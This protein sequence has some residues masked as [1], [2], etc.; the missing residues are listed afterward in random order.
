VRDAH[1]VTGTVCGGEAVTDPQPSPY[2]TVDFLTDTSTVG[3]PY[4]YYRY[5]RDE[6]GPAWI[7]PIWNV[8]MVT[9]HAEAMAVYRD[10]ENFSSCN[11]PSG[12]W[13]GLPERPESDDASDLIEQYRSQM[14]LY[15]YMVTWDP[16][17]HAAYRS[18]LMGLF[19][20][21]RLAENE[22]FMWRLADE[23]LERFLERGA[24]DFVREFAEPFTF[25]V[26]A[27]LLG[28]PDDDLGRFRDWFR[29]Q[30]STGD[31]DEEVI[32]QR[33]AEVEDPNILGF[34]ESTFTEYI[35]DRRRHPRDDILTHLAQVTFPDGSVPELSVLANEAAFLFAAGQETTARTLSFA[36][37]YLAARPE[38]QQALRADRGLIPVFVE[39]I[40]RLESPIKVH[41]R[42]ARRTVTLGGVTI[43][44]GTTVMLMIGAINRDPDRFADPD[45]LRLDRPN[46]F[47]HI[48]FAKGA[49]SC[50]G[51]QL[52]RTEARVSLH[53]LLDRVED[54][55]ISETHHG[56]PGARQYVYD[57]TFLFRGLT[58]LHVEF[59]AR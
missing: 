16:P 18:L 3:D 12:P 58:A 40:L 38:L 45:E 24:C 41:F 31:L 7:D 52:A 1:R 27:N 28:V 32:L 36:A 5:L 21:T 47:E 43:P 13:P 25:L 57:P 11:A 46:L 19:T 30:K 56:P 17:Q 44:A 9:G 35:A 54:I 34:F 20:P 53:R 14:A 10:D 42:M 4:R 6:H 29:S 26:V 51:Q 33:L 8:A 15:G 50:L 23:E 39:E 49:H 48:A 2:A 55:R 59:T 22:A 37:Q